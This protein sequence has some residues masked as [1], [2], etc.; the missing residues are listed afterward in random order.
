ME[1]RCKSTL[2]PC[3][4]ADGM[5]IES[6]PGIGP[7]TANELRAALRLS[8]RT[9]SQV[10]ETARTEHALH[11]IESGL[12]DPAGVLVGREEGRLVGAMLVQPLAGA[13]GLVWPVQCSAP[14]GV[15]ELENRLMERAR[16]WLRSHG[17]K[18]VQCLLAESESWAAPVLQRNGFRHVTR[19]WYMRHDLDAFPKDNQELPAL[20]LEPYSRCDPLDFEN[21]LL[22]TYESTVD[23]PEITGV[24]SGREIIAGHKAQ[25]RHDPNRWWLAYAHGLP[26]GVLLL[27]ELPEGPGWDLSYLGLVRKARG[28]GFGKSLVEHALLVCRAQGASCLTLSVDG[29]NHPA[30]R[31]YHDRGF[32]A[33]DEREVFLDI[34][35]RE[36]E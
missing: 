31:L 22:A 26:A 36:N 21:V 18:I 8:L 32:H 35:P 34:L 5:N 20:Q 25:G 11:L 24:R 6:L 19:L 1:F 7:A 29:R 16:S 3:A 4:V 27:S 12:F 33:Y 13:S 9:G 14:A 23:C 2:D 30:I 17:T 15:A 10:Q 28:Q